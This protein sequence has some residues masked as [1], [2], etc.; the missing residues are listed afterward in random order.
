MSQP[1]NAVGIPSTVL[2]VAQP[3]GP[4]LSSQAVGE[5]IASGLSEAGMPPPAVLPLDQES[6]DKLT[7]AKLRAARALIVAT[8]RLH[9]RTLVASVTF[10]IATRARQSGVPC[11]A[12]AKENA[13]SPFDARMLDLQVVLQAGSK[14]AL[15]R[16]GLRLAQTA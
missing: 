6:A 4:G 15:R 10:E 7:D 3:F 2:I 11:Y 14:A 1:R 5:A 9:D 12:V 8:P 16:A 13:L